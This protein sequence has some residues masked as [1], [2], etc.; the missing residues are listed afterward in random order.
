MPLGM[1]VIHRDITY[2]EATT[3][4]AEFIYLVVE[5]TMRS[6][7]EQ[8]WGSFSEEYNRKNIAETIAAK[9]YSIIEY[10]GEDIGAISIE[11]HP[12]F[13]QLTQLF[14]LPS[15]QNRGIGTT[16]V[17]ELARESRQSGKPVRLRVLRTNPARRLYERE[18]FQVSSV[19]PERVYLELH[20]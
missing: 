10:Q 11:R 18:G 7:V 1:Q 3:A 8:I 12:D 2:R 13:I 6:Y 14:I 15:H 17:R 4:D 5:V 19:T 16:L 20:A 9:N